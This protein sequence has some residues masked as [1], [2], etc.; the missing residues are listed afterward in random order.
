MHMGLI[1]VSRQPRV[2]P[3]FPQHPHWVV[4]LD[5]FHW[6]GPEASSQVGSSMPNS[7]L[8]SLDGGI[9]HYH[10]K[11]PHQKW[12]HTLRA[13]KNVFLPEDNGC[14]HL[15]VSPLPCLLRWRLPLILPHSCLL[16]LLLHAGL[17]SP[18]DTMTV[19]LHVSFYELRTAFRSR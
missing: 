1:P 2:W 8:N 5:L 17:L 18:H 12:F 6:E 11:S 13:R 19:W 15:S 7:C 4:S 9:L 3:P 10:T 14:C 16:S